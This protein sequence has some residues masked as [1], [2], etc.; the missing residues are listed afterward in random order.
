MVVANGTLVVLFVILSFGLIVPELFRKF[1][2]PWVTSLI[3]IGAILGPHTLGFL[4]I[5]PVIEFFGFFGSAFLMLLAG[6]E[7]NPK[8]VRALGSKIGLMALINGLI[9]FLTGLFVIRFFGYSWTT[10]LLVATVFISS[11]IAIVVSA[12]RDA[13]LTN[14]KIGQS[15]MSAAVL[16]DIASLLLLALIL[17]KVAPITSL[18]LPAYIFALIGALALFKIVVPKL[19]AWLDLHVTI[20]HEEE[21][22]LR[23]VI[24]ILLAALLFFSLIG[25]HS[26]IAAFIVGVVLSHNITSQKLYTKLHTI[27]YG[28]FVPVFFVVAGMEMDLGLLFKVEFGNLVVIAIVVS[29]IAA[30]LISGYIGARLAGFKH[31]SSLLFGVGSM[32]QLTTTLAVTYA[33]VELGLFDTAITTGVLLLSVVTTLIAPMLLTK[34][35]TSV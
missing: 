19:A 12:L 23:L 31:K 27:G 13:K 15:I 35:K 24:V 29:S 1:K 6:L 14:S 2:L 33:A 32:P 11:A 20:H 30:K 17:Q 25:V 18:S 16:E 7:L 34:L 4:Q 8:R 21:D 28:L 10:S 5:D 22:Q 3:I 26:L 9:P